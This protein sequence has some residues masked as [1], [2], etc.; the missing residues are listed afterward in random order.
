MEVSKCKLCGRTPNYVYRIHGIPG[1]VYL[2]CSSVNCIL[3][4][5]EIRIDEWEKLMSTPE[6]PRLWIKVKQDLKYNC[7]VYLV[8]EDSEGWIGKF[9]V[10]GLA[11]DHA[12][13]FSKMLGNIPI[14]YYEETIVV[15]EKK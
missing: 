15:R 10:L 11:E 2:Q 6:L 3:H 7:E 12:E 8:S 4:G 1:V 9:S 13:F 14:E 5:S